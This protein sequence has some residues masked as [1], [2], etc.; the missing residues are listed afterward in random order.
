MT[1]NRRTALLVLASTFIIVAIA[2]GTRQSF[3]LFMRPITLDLGWGRETLSLVIALQ[4]LLNGLAAPFAGA[5]ADKWGTGRVVFTGSLFYA[6]GL[7][8]MSQSSTPATMFFG[9]SL[10]IGMGISACGLPVMLAAAARFAPEEKRSLWLGIVTAGATA[11]QLIIIPGVQALITQQGWSTALWVLAIGFLF[12]LPLAVYLGAASRSSERQK[13]SQSLSDALLEAYRH[14][15]YLL[16][17]LGF[18]VCGFQVQFIATHFPA[19]IEDSGFSKQLAANSLVVIAFFNMAGAWYAGYLGGKGRKKYLL[20]SIYLVRMIAIVLFI[21]LPMTEYSV[22]IFSATIGFFWL[23][24]VPLTS[25]LIA[26]IFGARY[27]ATLYAIVYLSHQA[28]NF[29]GAWVGG[30]IFDNAGNYDLVWW[31][32]AGLGLVAALLH[33]PI[34]DRPVQRLSTAN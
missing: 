8:I 10:L 7:V 11:G 6:V 34:D 21:S 16:L 15:G 30:W 32:A 25:G 2:F 33:A 23:G 20:S 9:G 28:G 1:T 14:R 5:I 17:T 13:D 18:F 12:L 26:Q 22:L 27:M 19:F 24:T 3:G 29:S 31:I 4:A